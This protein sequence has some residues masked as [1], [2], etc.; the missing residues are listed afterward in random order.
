[1]SF[2]NIDI[3]SAMRRL[4]ERRIEEAMR[5]GKFDNLPGAGKPLEL[6]PM[7]ANEDARLV[8]WALR[9]LKNNEFTPE[10]VRW[11]KQIDALRD[12]VS[13]ATSERR[14]KALVAAHNTLV[15]QINTMGTN[16]LKA[17]VAPLSL[18][19]ELRKLRERQGIVGPAPP[20]QPAIAYAQR[21]CSYEACRCPNPREARFCRRCGR[22]IAA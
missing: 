15:H 16:A 13:T 7:P 4:A 14:V 8:W 9:V 20:S 5:E 22:E 10:E 18:E 6:E 1:M 11:R 12:E 21:A 19:A 17:A 2:K 3:E